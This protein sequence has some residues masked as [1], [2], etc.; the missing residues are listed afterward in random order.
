MSAEDRQRWDAKYAERSVAAEL[1]PHEWLVACASAL[2]P[3]RALDVA[4]GLGHNAVWLASRGWTVDAIDISAGGLRLAEQLAEQHGQHVNWIA[5]DL[6][7]FEV[8][9]ERYD[10]ICV[11]RFLDRQ[12]LPAMIVNALRPGGL[13]VYETFTVRELQRAGSNQLRN[14]A[15]VLQPGQLPTLYASLETLDYRELDL[16]EHSVAR[17][18]ARKR[19]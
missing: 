6:D 19:V 16:V 18:L 2:P 7:N 4:A 12:R 17:L 10:L 9:R 15:F 5:A 11:V 13:L 3:G 1:A 8:P 14:P